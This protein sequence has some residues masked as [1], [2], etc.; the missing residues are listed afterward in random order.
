MILSLLF[1]EPTIFLAW[2]IA[3]IFGITIHEFSHALGANLLGDR[4]PKYEGRLTLNPLAHL[5]FLGFM[6]LLFAGFGW[7]KPVTYNPFNLKN[8]RWGPV[9]VSLFGPLSNFVA[10]LIFGFALKILLAYTGLG[11]ENMLIIFLVALIHINLVL[12]IF[13]LIPIPPLDGHHVLYAFLPPSADSFKQ[14]F[15]RSGPMLLLGLIV[16]DSFLGLSIFSSVFEAASNVI[17]RIFG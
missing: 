14:S 9:L 8:R 1:R 12:G 5:D 15:E 2:L 13:N 7:G 17:F 11:A 10:L 6:V 16:L 4:T 3:I